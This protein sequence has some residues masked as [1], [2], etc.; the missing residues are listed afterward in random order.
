MLIKRNLIS[1]VSPVVRSARVETLLGISVEPIH[2]S[3]ETEGILKE[4]ISETLGP[5]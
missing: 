4:S 1:Q 5:R 2:C 3:P